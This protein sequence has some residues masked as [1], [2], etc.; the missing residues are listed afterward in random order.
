M[1]TMIFVWIV[2]AIAFATLILVGLK[3]W[4]S[5]PLYQIRVKNIETGKIYHTSR[6]AVFVP[7]K[8]M[9]AE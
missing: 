3:M 5:E 9:E 2:V 6:W 4:S 7:I 8:P 1:K